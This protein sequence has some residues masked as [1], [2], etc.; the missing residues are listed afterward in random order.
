MGTLPEVVNE[1]RVM[2]KGGATPSRLI[3]YIGERHR[4]EPGLHSLIQAYFHEAFDVPIV[5]GVK[6]LDTHEHFDLRYAFLNGSLL[7]EMIQRRGQW[8]RD[9]EAPGTETW[10]DGLRAR[11]DH[12]RIRQ[13]QGVP[14]PNLKRCWSL[15][16]PDEQYYLE[17]T[18]ASGAGLSERV[19]I[20]T[21]LAEC[22]QQRINEL[23]AACAP[24]IHHDG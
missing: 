21:R 2:F 19:E 12:E 3:R 18:A 15:L 7:Y 4:G 23:E 13:A 20:L 10:L 24:A 1:L 5:R 17:M 14:N 9:D 11:D 8:D 22:L 6:P 16:T